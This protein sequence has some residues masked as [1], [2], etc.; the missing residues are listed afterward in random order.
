MFTNN[1]NYK[2][3]IRYLDSREDEQSRGIT[4]ESHA[5]SLLYKEKYLINLIDCPGHVDFSSDVSSAV[6]LCDG[7]LLVV[8][9]VRNCAKK[10]NNEANN[11]A[12][13]GR[14]LRTNARGDAKRVGG[15]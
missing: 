14:R 6:R 2:G 1:N 15:G 7:A 8:D 9:V 4:M 3:K 12:K 13:G 10:K 11:E 5:I